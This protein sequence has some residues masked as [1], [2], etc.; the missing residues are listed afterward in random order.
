MGETNYLELRLGDVLA[1]I[2]ASDQ[3]PGGGSA[4]ALT[5][6][7]AAGLV[8]MVA[9]C[10]HGSWSEGPGVAAQALAIQERVMPLADTDARAWD[11]ALTALRNAG[12]TDSGGD[13]ELERK[14]ELAAAVPLE[15]AQLGA[16]VAAL[17]ALAGERCE[18]A[19]H[20]DA[21]A[22]AA[23]AAG[24]ARAAAHLVRANLAVRDGDERLR[25]AHV[26]EQAALDAAERALRLIR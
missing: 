26:S 2:A 11:E 8:A 9:R 17:A 3:S 25:R 19:Y 10:S 24:G 16:D 12:D 15:I 6:A 21:A 22:A 7:V 14:L 5:V 1:R 18:G 13:F 4:A 20:A 23:L